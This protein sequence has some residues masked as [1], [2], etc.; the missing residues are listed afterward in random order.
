[1][2]LR[3]LFHSSYWFSQPELATHAVRWFWIVLFLTLILAG[4]VLLFLRR[5]QEAKALQAVFAGLSRCTLTLGIL[6]LLWFYFR[7]ER[8]LVLGWRFWL[9]LWVV[10]LAIWL[11][12]ILWYAVKRLPQIKAENKERENREKYLPKKK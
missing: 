10:V 5:H 9:L 7:Q 2:S 8:V 11:G 4:L 12:R 6:G 1:M 3:N